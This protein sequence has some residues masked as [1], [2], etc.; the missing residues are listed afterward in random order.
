MTDG[1]PSRWVAGFMDHVADPL[2]LVLPEFVHP[3]LDA[4]T[5]RL[6]AHVVA[7]REF[8]RQASVLDG[9][10]HPLSSSA[11]KVPES[12]PAVRVDDGGV[13]EALK[14]VTHGAEYEADA[15]GPGPQQMPV[16]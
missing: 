14:L 2:I 10:L 5:I 1:G 6:V 9:H 12:R 3:V 13:D 11:E 16:R 7:A 4:L 15:A 8:H